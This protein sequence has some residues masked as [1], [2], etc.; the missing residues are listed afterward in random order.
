MNYESAEEWPIEVSHDGG[1]ITKLRVNREDGE[2]CGPG[3]TVC[4]IP[5]CAW[6]YR[7]NGRS[8]LEWIVERY[9]DETDKASGIRNDCN[10]WG[11]AEYVLSLI[12][13]VVTVSV[14]TVRILEGLPELGV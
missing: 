7:V 10:E 4:G 13:R 2:I 14:E 1:R 9:K 6:E 8:A 11:G 5:A 3:V 12:R